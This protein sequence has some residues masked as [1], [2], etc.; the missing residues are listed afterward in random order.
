MN[1]VLKVLEDQKDNRLGHRAAI[2]K[3]F[4]FEV[5]QDNHLGGIRER[6]L[7]GCCKNIGKLRA[8][9]QILIEA[10]IRISGLLT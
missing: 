4:C 2:K 1:L 7:K 5:N 8:L 10:L 9:Y 3:F 6:I